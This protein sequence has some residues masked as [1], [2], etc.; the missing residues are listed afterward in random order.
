MLRTHFPYFPEVASA[1]AQFAEEFSDN[2]DPWQKHAGLFV[3]C[4]AS[5]IA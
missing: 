3:L 4:T 5:L 2:F 1:E